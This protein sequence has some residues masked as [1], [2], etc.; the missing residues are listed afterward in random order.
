MN[1]ERL[2]ELKYRLEEARRILPQVQYLVP[3]IPNLLALIEEAK[4]KA[5]GR[6]T[7]P[8]GET[9]AVLSPKGTAIPGG[10]ITPSADASPGPSDEERREMVVFLHKACARC[11][12]RLFGGDDCGGM[13]TEGW[14]AKCYA[15]KQ[16]IR[17]LLLAP[18]PSVTREQV[19]KWAKT[20]TAVGDYYDKLTT[21]EIIA[22]T[23]ANANYLTDELRSLGVRVSG[24]E[25]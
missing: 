4:L 9:P 25:E 7:A 12:E 5:G 16:A 14:Q 1:V 15:R 18:Q 24:E 19:K 23:E 8:Q 2:D 21:D 3:A 22:A 13:F 11:D 6:T 17:R 20:M 10:P